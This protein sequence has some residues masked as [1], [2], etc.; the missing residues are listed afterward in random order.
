VGVRCLRPQSWS[1]FVPVTV[2][3]IA[4]VVV[5]AR[6]VARGQV[7][8]QTDLTLLSRDVTQLPAGVL[9]DLEQAL[10]KTVVAALP[11]G[12]AVRA[13]MLRAPPAIS[14]GQAVRIIYQGGGFSVS[15]EGRS[16]STAAVGQPAR[17]RIASGKVL[18]GIVHSPGVVEV[19]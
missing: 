13:D 11:G 16:L 4:D 1:V 5:T 10:G 19:K 7:L 9:N 3:V 15:S 14:Q 18:E 12:T 2:R 17:V 8:S 6:G